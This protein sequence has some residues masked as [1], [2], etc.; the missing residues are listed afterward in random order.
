MCSRLRL[1]LPLALGVL[2]VA[3][4][5]AGVRFATRFGLSP[6]EVLF[7]GAARDP[8]GALCALR[9]LDLPVLIMPYIGALKSYVFMPIF[10]LAGVTTLSI[11]LP[12][13]LCGAVTIL[14]WFAT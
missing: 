3:F 12:M 9:F 10:R 1:G 7:V 5:A 13:V 11:R 6:D 4:V 2:L 8:R 14:V